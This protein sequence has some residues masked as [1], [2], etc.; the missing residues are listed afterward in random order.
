LFSLAVLTTGLI[1][2]APL[3]AA[4]QSCNEECALRQLASARFGSSSPAAAQVAPP[5]A[6]RAALTTPAQVRAAIDADAQQVARLVQD[7]SIPQDV[8]VQ[9]M[10]AL[11]NDFAQLVNQLQSMR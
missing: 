10:A 3:P 7:T 9:Q 4:A 11:A 8:K 1:A 6:G 2:F 5:Q